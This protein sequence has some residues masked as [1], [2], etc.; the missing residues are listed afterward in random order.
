LFN[1][2]EYAYLD[3]A[4]NVVPGKTT[5]RGYPLRES[6]ISS[7][8]GRINYDYNETYLTTVVLRA[9]GSSNFARG[10]QWG[11]FPSISAGWVVS[12]ESFMEKTQ[13][14]MDFLKL[15]ASWGQ[16]GNQ[17]IEPFQYLGIYAFNDADY[18]FGADKTF[19]TTGAYP[20]ILPNPDITWE[21]SEQTDFGFDARF[22]N[23]HL[24][25]T[26]DWYS[27]KTIDWLVQAPILGSQGANPP[28]INGGDISNK[29][30]EVALTWTEQA[31]NGFSY[32]IS[33]SMAYNRNEVTRIAN[34]EGII[35][36]WRVEYAHN[37]PSVYRAEVGY[38]IGY[39]YGYQ[40]AGVFQNQAQIDS[41]TG[42]KQ[43]GTKPGDLIFVDTNHNGEI[44]V[45][46]QTMIGDPN[47]DV[48]FGL[49]FIAGYKTW[50]SI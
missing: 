47:P 38:P 13:S 3:N 36:G 6:A 29:G 33:A 40:T 31:N 2:F 8:F 48:T 42:A 21:T 24:G 17:N 45:K 12:N 16:N 44:D 25:L 4:K 50:R 37:V 11:Y 28:Y 46:D 15:R 26:F 14:W 27:K 18:F 39:F 23:S 19:W 30:I 43:D 22:F 9:D 34:T 5:L 7:F 32:Q 20:S 49:N 10:H 41:Y 35:E 1:S